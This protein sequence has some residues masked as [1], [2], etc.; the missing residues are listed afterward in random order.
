MQDPSAYARGATASGKYQ[1]VN[2][3]WREALQLAGIDPSQYPTARSAPE[4]V[5]DK[6]AQ[7]LYGK[8]G[9]APWDASKFG[10]NWVTQPG[11]GYQLVKGAQP[12]ASGPGSAPQGPIK[13]PPAASTAA[14]GPPGVQMGG[15]A[16]APPGGAPGAYS[17]GGI[18]TAL[19]PELAGRTPATVA[20]PPTTAAAA[21]PGMVRLPNGNIVTKGG[22]AFPGTRA[23]A[24]AILQGIQTAQAA[25]LVRG[26]GEE[27][28]PSGAVATLAQPPAAQPGWGAQV[29]SYN[30]APVGPVTARAAPAPAP[31][32]PAASP[33]PIAAA[34]PPGG[35]AQ[36]PAATP[37]AAPPPAPATSLEDYAKQHGQGTLDQPDPAS[38]KAADAQIR[39]A[40]TQLQE[41][42]NDKLGQ[43]DLNKA[44]GAV[45][46]AQNERDKLFSDARDKFYSTIVMPG[47]KAEQDRAL[48]IQKA[49]R[50]PAQPSQLAA[51]GIT[52]EPGVNYQVDPF[53]NITMQQ[54]P[55]D[56]RL[57][58]LS[59]TDI[60]RFDTE[61][62]KPHD[63]LQ[64]LRPMMDQMDA[65]RQQMIRD[66]S[67]NTGATA[68]AI[69]KFKGVLVSA[70]LGTE[71]MRE[72]LSNAEAYKALAQQLVLAMKSNTGLSR[73]TNYDLQ[74]LQN[75]I[76]TWDMSALGQEK[77]SGLLRQLW[78]HQDQVYGAAS[79]SLHDRSTGYTLSGMDDRVAKLPEA[80]PTLPAEALPQQGK[81]GWN[82]QQL[83]DWRNTKGLR[84]GQVF[85]M[86]SGDY[87]V[88]GN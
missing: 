15:P 34:P 73:L 46:A 82:T 31:T 35:P 30:N 80:I 7:A 67:M 9:T 23:D 87:Q 43:T 14:A 48:E 55:I 42:R 56:P 68:D 39:A 85:R 13:G 16:P 52:P 1:M 64:R 8:Y 38:V 71:G 2:S 76:P 65:L 44:L 33:P 84:K 66:G 4:A 19:N 86:P 69:N 29:G 41:A 21:P 24:D 5:Q 83:T 32:T 18:G 51:A 58:K 36:P 3:T 62:A 12:P 25:P 63:E 17:G 77:L 10:A 40:Q 53:G 47:F 70:G 37:P 11:G 45:Q 78:D 54:V 22:G 49:T 88:V 79:G 50:M 26:T 57:Q 72:G 20:P 75:Q 27:A 81:S 60:A 61:Y 6:A 28:G 74:I 59:D